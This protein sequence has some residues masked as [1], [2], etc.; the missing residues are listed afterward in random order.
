[1]KNINFRAKGMLVGIWMPFIL[2]FIAGGLGLIILG[3]ET[4]LSSSMVFI[5]MSTPFTFVCCMFMTF[6]KKIIALD[7]KIKELE[8]KKIV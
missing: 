6:R 7:D 4:D 5:S 2:C 3:H 1:M 8:E